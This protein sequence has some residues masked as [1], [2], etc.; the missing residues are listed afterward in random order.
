M[1][2]KKK[3]VYFTINNNNAYMGKNIKQIYMY[4]CL[5]YLTNNIL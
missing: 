5:L 1:S 4:Y 3:Y 2:M